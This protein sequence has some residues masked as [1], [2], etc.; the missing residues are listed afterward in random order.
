[1]QFQRVFATGSALYLVTHGETSIVGSWSPQVGHE[2]DVEQIDQVQPAIK[3]EPP[4]LPVLWHKA[5]INSASKGEGVDE[6]EAENHNDAA[7]DAPPQLL[8]H[9]RLSLLLPVDEILHGGIERVQS[10]HVEGRQGAGERKNDQ[11]H[12]RTSAIGRDGQTGDGV[13]DRKD[14]VRDGQDTDVDH[15]PA[16]GG[17]DHTVAHADDQEEEK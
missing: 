12:E 5:G 3:N 11:E 16:Q 7:E 4:G 14:K 8:V 9:Q 15:G 6:K 17:L 13:D 2:A 1:M 10:P